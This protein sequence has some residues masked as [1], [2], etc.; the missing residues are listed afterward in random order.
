M[1]N[2]ATNEQLD[3]YLFGEMTAAEQ[4]LFL[5]EAA[6][7]PELSR[8]IATEQRITETLQADRSAAPSN[9]ASTRQTM[10]A[11]A[12]ATPAAKTPSD[13]GTPGA[14]TSGWLGKM[15]A[16]AVA[17]IGVV[18][19]IIWLAS[20]NDQPTVQPTPAVR[21]VTEPTAVPPQLQQS[22]SQL[23]AA[24]E[25]TAPDANREQPINGAAN[26]RAG[27]QPTS[28]AK[29]PAQKPAPAK[30]SQQPVLQ[31]PDSK[32]PRSTMPAPINGK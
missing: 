13:G 11:L 19:G 10:L 22:E 26:R 32:P 16:G 29:T 31:G 27:A 25:Q 4:Q 20:G 9:H 28:Q 18:G 1:M 17:T 6:S 30:P 15:I 7:N 14:T 23:P 12:A 21:S 2:E 5:D 3:R 8:A 24:T